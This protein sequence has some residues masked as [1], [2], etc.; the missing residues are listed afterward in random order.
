[1]YCCSP[2]AA[3]SCNHAP[4]GMPACEACL[5]SLRAPA[6]VLFLSHSSASS[7]E[8][9]A[10]SNG[11]DGP[12]WGFPGTP[13]TAPLIRNRAPDTWAPTLCRCRR[14]PACRYPLDE[15]AAQVLY[16][17]TSADPAADWLEGVLPQELRP[18]D[19]PARREAEPT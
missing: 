12:V 4:C 9:D 15:S 19:A 11:R 2:V 3:S 16:C 8:P 1:M 14:L 7:G 10:L 17:C 13:D 6:G 5:I 18:R